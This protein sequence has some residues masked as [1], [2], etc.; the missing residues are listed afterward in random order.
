MADT[1]QLFDGPKLKVERANHHINELESSLSVFLKMQP[2]S[3]RV[4]VDPT[5]G[6]N[7][8]RFHTIKDPPADLPLIIGDAAHNLRS[9]LDL[10]WSA[11]LRHAGENDSS[12]H[13]PFHETREN[14]VDTIDK[15]AVKRAF[16]AVAALILD[17][18]RPHKRGDDALWALNKLDVLD[19]HRLLIP[20]IS[21]VRLS[22]V[23][24]ED[25]NQNHF[26]NMTLTVAA[27]GRIITPVATA[28]RLNIKN[29]GEPT[30]SIIFGKDQPLVGEPIIPTLRQLAQSV[31]GIIYT[32]EAMIIGPSLP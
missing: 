18:I 20:V 19:K 24:L 3:I 16:P 5:T 11:I 30:V 17:Q 29:Y 6:Q 25:E 10:M 8:L 7:F 4:D 15:G 2:Y 9:A 13:F 27:D 26:N 22:G 32:I 12:G 1:K 28:A 21:A 23:D 31:R 14:L